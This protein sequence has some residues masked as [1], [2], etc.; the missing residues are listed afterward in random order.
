MR[1][2]T[3]DL[4][5]ESDADQESGSKDHF[6]STWLRSGFKLHDSAPGQCVRC[7]VRSL[8]AVWSLGETTLNPDRASRSSE[9]GFSA[10]V[11]S[12]ITC[13]YVLEIFFFFLVVLVYL[14]DLYTI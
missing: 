3:R 14:Y 6:A 12:S 9:S 10:R 2:S 11:E 8:C 13:M 4:G 7:N 1:L 5:S